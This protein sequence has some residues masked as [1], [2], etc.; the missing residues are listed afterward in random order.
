MDLDPYSYIHLRW[1]KAS[2]NCRHRLILCSRDRPMTASVMKNRGETEPGRRSR[3]GKDAESW[4]LWWSGGSPG[5]CSVLWWLTVVGAA[6]Q[7][8]IWSNLF[9]FLSSFLPI[10]CHKQLGMLSTSSSKPR[11]TTEA[12]RRP[13]KITN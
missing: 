3:M 10:C 4:D 7:S 13:M 1:L 12:L 9:A 5:H 6:R 11:V 8:Y 2:L